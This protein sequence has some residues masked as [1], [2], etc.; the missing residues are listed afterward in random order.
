MKELIRCPQCGTG[1]KENSNFCEVCGERLKHLSNFCPECGKENV[2]IANFCENCG[3]RLETPK[4]WKLGSKV[5]DKK[6]P[7]LKANI[8]GNKP[9][10][11]VSLDL[12]PAESLM[13]L[14]HKKYG[15]KNS[16][17]ELLKVTLMDLIFKDVFKLEVQEIEEGNK[18]VKKIYLE[19]GKNFNMPL[20]PHEEV[21]K[22]Y[23]PPI[24]DKKR[25][26]TL[27]GRVYRNAV[28]YDYVNKRLLKP[29]Y[30]D[31]FFTVKKSF[32]RKKCTLSDKGLESQKIIK[33]LKSY[34]KNL[35]NWI[36]TDPEKAKTYLLIGGSNIFLTDKRNFNWF[37]NNHKRIGALFSHKKSHKKI[38]DLDD[39]FECL[40]YSAFISGSE[41]VDIDNIGDIFSDFDIFDVFD[42]IDAGDSGFDGFSDEGFDGGSEGGLWD[43]F[44]GDGFDGGDDG[45]GGD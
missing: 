31:G 4:S 21:F 38:P 33:Q 24:T 30:S 32:L 27:Q 41:N 37:K 11:K 19:E 20:K 12:T 39:F 2:E 45:G 16:L 34:G 5:Q 14:D 10:K 25:F 18:K 42:S 23:L 1:N 6:I 40:W 44:D 35:E 9:A 29:L 43:L 8:S 22:K 3:S 26:Q 13:I 17:K 15:R 7:D 36:E 28:R